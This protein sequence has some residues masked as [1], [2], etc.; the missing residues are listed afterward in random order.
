MPTASSAPACRLYWSCGSSSRNP[1]AIALGRDLGDALEPDESRAYALPEMLRRP[2]RSPPAH[3]VEPSAPSGGHHTRSRSA[4]TGVGAGGVAPT[5]LAGGGRAGLS[6]RPASPCTWWRQRSVPSMS[7]IAP[8]PMATFTIVTTSC[9]PK[10]K[11]R[12]VELAAAPAS[13]KTRIACC[14]PAP[15]G[16]EGEHRREP[17]D[18]EHGERRLHGRV[19]VERAEEE[20]G[21]A[22][23]GE[24]ASRLP[25]DHLAEVDAPVVEDGEAEHE[26]LP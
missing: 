18:D 24:P 14:V 6:S 26:L 21:R 13:A 4:A 16:R 1:S 8:K 17:A 19:H 20:E 5:A 10:L 9:W 7:R 23:S 11:A 15:P 25:G 22:D 2:P 3:S 12:M